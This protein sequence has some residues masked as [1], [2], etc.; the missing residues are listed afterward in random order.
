MALEYDMVFGPVFMLLL[1]PPQ[2]FNKVTSICS[3][4][5]LGLN[6]H[7]LPLNPISSPSHLNCEASWSGVTALLSHFVGLFLFISALLL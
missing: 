2:L 3:S 1:F 6:I 7:N 5:L 4:F